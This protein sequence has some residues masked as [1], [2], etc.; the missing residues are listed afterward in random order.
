MMYIFSKKKR[1][2]IAYLTWDNLKHQQQKRH[3]DNLLTD[4]EDSSVGESKL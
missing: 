4:E 3:Q 1:F 2:L